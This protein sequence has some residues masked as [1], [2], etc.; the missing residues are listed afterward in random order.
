MS[1]RLGDLGQAPFDR[2]HRLEVFLREARERGWF[3]Q[4]RDRTMV[5]QAAILSTYVT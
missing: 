1:G 2:V 5:S 4:I 3:R